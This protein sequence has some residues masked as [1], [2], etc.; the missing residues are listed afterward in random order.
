MFTGIVQETGLI[1]EV[2][3]HAGGLRL[4]VEGSKVARE[5]KNDDS[6]SVN[7]VCLTVAG[8]TENRL[9]FDVI[10]ETLNQTTLGNLKRGNHVNLEPAMR[11]GDRFDGHIVQGHVD[12]TAIIEE[13]ISTQVE[14]VVW[15]HPDPQMLTYIVPKGSV[16]VDGVSMTVAQL[17]DDLFSIAIIP[18]TRERTTLGQLRTG[19]SVNIESDMMARTIVHCLQRFLGS[20]DNRN[21]HLSAALREWTPSLAQRGLS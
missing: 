2:R 6:I 5:A 3:E 18:T 10:R 13:V 21:D 7:G 8:C 12:G 15:L 16:A 14:H 9:E 20:S 17:K 4:S 1:A 19:D 11:A